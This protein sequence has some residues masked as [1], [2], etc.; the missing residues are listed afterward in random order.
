MG[1]SRLVFERIGYTVSM[2]IAHD[3]RFTTDW[4]YGTCDRNENDMEVPEM[5]NFL[6]NT[7]R[8]PLVVVG[9]IL[10][11]ATSSYSHCQIPCGIYNDFARVQAM[12]EDTATI[13][14]ALTLLAELAG[15]NDA[16]SQNQ[17]V[18]WVVNKETHAQKIISTISDYFLTQ[19]VKPDQKD[20]TQRLAR[21]HAVIIA[22]MQAKQNSDIKYARRLRESIEALSS[23]YPEHTH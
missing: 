12:L 13:E 21:H 11:F 1:P 18:R 22:A 15:K 20:Y 3:T 19:R 9:C 2:Q 7:R 8:T 4:S 5:N 16:Q 23:Y 14:K 17:L 10:M 6:K